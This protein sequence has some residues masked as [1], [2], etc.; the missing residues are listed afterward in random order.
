M[1]FFQFAMRALGFEPKTEDV[2]TVLNEFNIEG[3]VSSSEFLDIIAAKYA[4]NGS[5]NEIMKAYTMFIGGHCGKITF[6]DLK[7][8]ARE[9]GETISDEEL[10]VS[11]MDGVCKISLKITTVRSSWNLVLLTRLSFIFCRSTTKT[12]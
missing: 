8:V 10:R 5:R 12:S 4:E 7:R 9:L 11:I 2:K 3:E 1:V 6:D